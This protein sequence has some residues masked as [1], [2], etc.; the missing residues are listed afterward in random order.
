MNDVPGGTRLV[1]ESE[2]PRRLPVRVVE[3]EYLSHDAARSAV[4]LSQ[5]TR[6][7]VHRHGSHLASGRG[8]P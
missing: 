8:L 4:R 3:K 1:G 2:E 6:E 5:R 7:D